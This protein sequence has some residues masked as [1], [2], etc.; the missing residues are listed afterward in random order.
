V[1]GVIPGQQ[2]R[3]PDGMGKA[4][5]LDRDDAMTPFE[6]RPARASLRRGRPALL[7]DAAALE[8]T[9]A[10]IDPPVSGMRAA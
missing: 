10:V 4:G 5:P 3:T 9:D 2:R 8:D 7:V 1:L 6:E